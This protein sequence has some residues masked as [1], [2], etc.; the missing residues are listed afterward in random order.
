MFMRFWRA[1]GPCSMY[2]RAVSLANI[3]G[4]QKRIEFGRLFMYIKNRGGPKSEP[5]GTMFCCFV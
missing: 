5:W 1:L 3:C 4:R 2:K